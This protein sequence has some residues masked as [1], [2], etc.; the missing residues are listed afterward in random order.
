MHLLAKAENA[1]PQS[2]LSIMRRG[3]RIVAVEHVD[4]IASQDELQAY[5]NRLRNESMI[6][7]ETFRVETGLLPGYGVADVTALHY[8]EFAAVCIERAWDM[9]LRPGGSMNHTLERVVAALG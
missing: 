9:E 2:P 4:N 7:A 8:G 1:N 5:A 6:T 3:R